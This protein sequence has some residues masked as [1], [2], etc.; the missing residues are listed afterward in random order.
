MVRVTTMTL[1]RFTI[2]RGEK[3]ETRQ[4]VMLHYLQ[5]ESV[6]IPKDDLFV[7]ITLHHLPATL[8]RLFALK[9]AYQYPGGIGEA[10]QDLMKKAIT[11]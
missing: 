1:F 9:V 2:K 10:V 11:E 8:V 7:T 6:Q 5:N 4:K 3:M